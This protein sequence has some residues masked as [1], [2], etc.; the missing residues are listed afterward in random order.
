MP[1][2][3]MTDSIAIFSTKLLELSEFAGLSGD[4]MKQLMEERAAVA[5][6]SDATWMEAMTFKEG[7]T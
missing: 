7:K 1:A 5:C 3:T 6:T 2:R 4:S